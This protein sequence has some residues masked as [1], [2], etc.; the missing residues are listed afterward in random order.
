MVLTRP[1]RAG[2]G[3]AA[4]A[5]LL[6]PALAAAPCSAQD[7][8]AA[9]ALANQGFELFEAS[10][11]PAAVD[12]FERAEQRCHSPRLLVFTG[13][14]EA[15][16]GRLLRARALFEQAAAEPTT[17]RSPASF[18]EAQVEARKELEAL[19][20]RVPTLQVFVTGAPA[21]EIA[22][23]LDGAPVGLAELS[24]AKELDPG[25]HTVTADAP[26]AERFVRHITLREGVVERIE[27][28]LRAPPAKEPAPAPSIAPAAVAF[29]VGALGVGLGAV[30]GLVSVSKV[31]DIESRC[32]GNQCLKSDAAEG[33][34][35]ATLG[36]VSTVSFIVGGLGV[37]AGVTL[38]VLRGGD[39]PASA[40]V[41]VGLGLGTMRVGGAF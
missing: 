17:P 34:T 40:P 3:A 1:R 16:R 4:A 28:A 38:L 25:E 2:R 7:R 22:L 35:A 29:G 13:R 6:A 39:D 19:R 11:Y 15:R 5:L 37:A 26:G 8:K 33:D 9:E 30:T 20:S 24:H 32:E 12:H 14:A 18:R 31:S 41:T 23:T 36:T 21:E 10:D 27:L